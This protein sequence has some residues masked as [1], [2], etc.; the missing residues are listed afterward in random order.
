MWLWYLSQKLRIILSHLIRFGLLFI[1]KANDSKNSRKNELNF[2]CYLHWISLQ[3]GKVGSR[4]KVW[5]QIIQAIQFE[6]LSS[7]N[8]VRSRKH[9]NNSS[10]ANILVCFYGV[11]SFHTSA[12]RRSDGQFRMPVCIPF[13]VASWAPTRIHC[14]FHLGHKS[15]C[16]H[17]EVE[18][19]LK[20][21]PWFRS[22]STNGR[23]PFSLILCK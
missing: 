6:N 11:T 13:S 20:N 17:R 23:N 10:W 8:S 2:H 9:S 7:F 14:S 4:P 12:R 1:P 22:A 16:S 18:E 15:N 19:R 3:L 21:S 5:P